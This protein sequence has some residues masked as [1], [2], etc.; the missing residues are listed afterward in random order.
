MNTSYS[1]IPLSTTKICKISHPHRN[2][3]PNLKQRNFLTIRAIN[4]KVSST[5]K[6]HTISKTATYTQVN[7]KT[8][9]S[10]ERASTPLMIIK[11]M[12]VCSRTARK[13]ALGFIDMRMERRMRGN[14]RTISSRVRAST[15]TRRRTS[16]KVC[17]NNERR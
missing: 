14:G 6:A 4:K 11:S 10:T 17:F 13:M 8:T 3:P 7:G 16:M 15:L 12:R 5:D 1:N 2:H 9:N